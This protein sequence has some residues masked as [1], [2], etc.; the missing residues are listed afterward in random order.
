MI[1]LSPGGAGIERHTAPPDRL[2]VASTDGVWFLC[3]AADG[4]WALD[5][6]EFAGTFVS[7]LARARDGALIAATHGFGLSRSDD[8]GKSWRWINAGLSQFDVWVVKALEIGGREVLLA[9][10][11]PAHLFVSDDGGAHWRELPALR[12]APSLPS[13]FFP[14]PPH[15]GHVKDIVVRDG[16]TMFIGIEVGALLRSDDEGNTFAEIAVFPDVTD[17]DIH[18]ILLHPARPDRFIIATGWGLRISEDA[19]KTWNTLEPAGINYPDGLVAHPDDPDLIFVAGSPGYPPNWFAINRS[20]SRIARSRDGGKTWQRLLTGLPSGG[21]PAFGAMTL[22]AWPGGY[23]VYAGDTDGQIFESR[24]GGESWEII[25]ETGAVS[26]GE[27]YRGLAK[28]R[29]PMVDLDELVFGGPGAHRVA[30][31]K[32]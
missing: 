12:A 6:K 28:G 9:G 25:F 3:R 27:H 8:E 24:D 13:W 2:A 18:R 20:R 16:R 7:A 19:G 14:P 22:A 23:A 21:R 30:T 10:G 17:R 26:K 1:L 31:T 15:L 32:A 11:M 29:P 5:H 4:D